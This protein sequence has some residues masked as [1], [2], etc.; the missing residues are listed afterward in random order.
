MWA[1]SGFAV[2]VVVLSL[3]KNPQHSVS[4]QAVSDFYT[5]VGMR[6]VNYLKMVLGQNHFSWTRG[7]SVILC[8]L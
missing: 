8:V 4:Y 5:V 2:V 6:S 3:D 1:E 7:P